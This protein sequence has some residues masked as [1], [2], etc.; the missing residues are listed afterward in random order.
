VSH[1]VGDTRHLSPSTQEAQRLPAV[2]AL[3]AGRDRED[4]ATAFSVSLKAV[5]KWWAKWQAEDREV[6]LMPRI[7]LLG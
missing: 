1:L 7:K 5:G 6:L 2:A 3:V 4:G